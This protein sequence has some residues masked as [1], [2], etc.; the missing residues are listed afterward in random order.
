MKLLGERSWLAPAFPEEFGG[1]GSSRVRQ[2]IVQDELSYYRALPI[3][4]VGVGIVGP[5]LLQYGS[6][7]QKRKFLPAIARGDV[8]FALGY[9]EPEAGSDLTNIQVK[10]VRE[11][12]YYVVNGQ[13][14]FN[15]GCHYAEYVWLAART[16]SQSV[17]SRGVSLFM[18]DMG[19][20]GITVRPIY[21]MDGERSNEVFYD[22]VRV[23]AD[24]LVGEENS[25]F[26]YML[27][28]LAH[29]RAFPIGGVR[30]TFEEF[31]ELARSKGLGSD[32]HARRVVAELAT[33]L[34]AL[35]LMAY[36]AAW[37]SDQH[38][39][40]EWE[41]PIVKLMLTEFM[42]KFSS[43]AIEMLGPGAVL[44]GTAAGAVLEGRLQYLYRHAARRTI[45][46]GTSEVMRNAIA[47]RGLGLAR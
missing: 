36:R 37:L 20:P 8:E 43:A 31:L 46:G 28:A 33:E 41:A 45:S 9:T 29:E 12:D 1:M 30:R 4:F 35:G 16:S 40:P 44:E 21:I 26:S 24:S 34:E 11:G 10:A 3:A 13:K 38:R 2:F 23:P 47:A 22:N 32:A 25:G 42:K 15:T 39:V 17:K 27:T 7:G 6:E 18:V 14:M 5:T 19:T